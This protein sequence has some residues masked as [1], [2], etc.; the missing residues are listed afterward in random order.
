MPQHPLFAARYFI[1][2]AFDRA[3]W[4]I[5]RKIKAEP[6]RDPEYVYAKTVTG[7]EAFEFEALRS[8]FIAGFITQSSLYGTDT[9]IADY[10]R[11][12]WA[13]IEQ[14]K[15]FRAPHKAAEYP[16]IKQEFEAA[17]QAMLEWDKKQ[18]HELQ[19]PKPFNE[20]EIQ[21]RIASYAAQKLQFSGLYSPEEAETLQC[22]Q[23][24]TMLDSIEQTSPIISIAFDRISFS[25]HDE[26]TLER[27][28]TP[29]I[30]PFGTRQKREPTFS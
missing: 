16:V 17:H 27:L 23:I 24:D 8:M 1:W 3:A 4:Q 14:E 20:N 15:H 25:L 7:Q 12:C 22:F 21:Q 26:A 6:N 19:N 10:V 28:E 9:Q 11:Q 18:P 30:T 29:Q 2:H 5:D 13:M